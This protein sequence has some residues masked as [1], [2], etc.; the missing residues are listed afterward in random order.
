MGIGIWYGYRYELRKSVSV[1]IFSRVSV[2]VSGYRW[3]TRSKPTL[4]D[5]Y[6]PLRGKV[7]QFSFLPQLIT[8]SLTYSEYLHYLVPY[9]THIKRFAHTTQLPHRLMLRYSITYLTLPHLSSPLLTSPHLFSPLLTSHY[10]TLTHLT[11]PSLKP[12]YSSTSPYNVTLQHYLPH[13]T[14]P[15]LTLPHLTSPLLTSPLLTS[16][17]VTSLILI[18]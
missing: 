16:P 5:R 14:S 3:N 13:L 6:E 4:L 8:A 12:H 7:C 17:H 10:L 15:Y 9:L 11:S 2:S 18:T 1:W